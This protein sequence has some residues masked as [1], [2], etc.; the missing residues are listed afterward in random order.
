M[1]VYIFV[2]VQRNILDSVH[3]NIILLLHKN[4]MYTNAQKRAQAIDKQADGKTKTGRQKGRWT[5]NR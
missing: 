4:T 5:K 2:Y 1:C 3:I